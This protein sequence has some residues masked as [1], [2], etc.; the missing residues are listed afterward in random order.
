MVRDTHDN[1]ADG[2]YSVRFYL[3]SFNVYND[4]KVW[5]ETCFAIFRDLQLLY[6]LS[7]WCLRVVYTSITRTHDRMMV[8]EWTVWI[9]WLLI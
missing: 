9:L 4:V 2:F 7:L 3:M 6:R 5:I 8:I 1:G